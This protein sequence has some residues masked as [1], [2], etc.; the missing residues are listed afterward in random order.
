MILK[1][2]KLDKKFNGVYAL[3]GLDFS[4]E[5]GEVRGLVGENG[6]GKSTFIKLLGGVYQ[7][8]GGRI[9]LDDQEVSFSG[10]K[11]SSASGISVLF[12]DSVLIPGF[13]SLE[14]VWLGYPYPVKGGLIRWKS[15]EEEVQKKAEE[16]GI[17][18]DLKKPVAKLGP[19]QKK[20]LEIVRAMLNRDC[21]LLILDEPTASFS[22]KET[23]LLFQIIHAL[24]EKGTAVL[25]VS[26][27]LEEIMELTDQVT[28]LQNGK[29]VDTLKTAGTT[30]E[31]L[32]RLMSGEGGRAGK[33][34]GKKS[35]P[36]VEEIPEESRP[37][38][39][40]ESS[41]F[42]ALEIRNLYSKD[43]VVRGAS[44]KLE[45]GRITGLFGLCGSGRTEFLES[46]FGY[47]KVRSGEIRIGGQLSERP[48]PSNSIRNKMVLIS[49]DRRGKALIPSFTIQDNM[50][51]SSI[52]RCSE[53]GRF[54]GKAAARMASGI[55]NALD[56]KCTGIRQCTAELSGGNQQKVV[57]AK[58]MLTEP[59]IWLCDEPT[60]A[61]DISTRKEIHR[62]LR[63][64]AEN[65]K[66]VL[67]VSSDLTELLETAD[68][69]AVMAAGKVVRIFENKGLQPE[70]ILACCYHSGKREAG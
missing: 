28:V 47:R 34:V 69:I 55:V 67:F 58:A 25:Y 70:E 52:D 45:R 22:D 23:R 21:R 14:N 24:K 54:N 56:I 10:P 48:S 1:T 30:K 20:S 12:Q 2:E 64:E 6:A 16:I 15:M 40:S 26:H 13:S 41:G 60:Q 63:N 65:G 7:P 18:L 9:Y 29:L 39:A 38:A 35:V 11:K 43:Q 50:L 68:E 5:S 57:F 53:G 8:D 62:L 32:V 49:E 51:L 42:P 4:I 33:D 46:I 44:L 59:D 61:V 31:E 66:T 37:D 19:S 17:C 27:R 3:E 36:A